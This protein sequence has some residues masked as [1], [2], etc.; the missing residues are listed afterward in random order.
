MSGSLRDAALIVLWLL[1]GIAILVRSLW[2]AAPEKLVGSV[3]VGLGWLAGCS[4]PAVWVHSGTDPA[5]L[6]VA[7]GVLYTMGALGYHR[8]LPDPRPS[9]FGYHEVFHTWV[10]LAAACQYVS[11]ACVL[12]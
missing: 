12:L 8:R 9:G 4:V 3:Y 1:A 11:I 10:M 2:M 6:L 5:S 7:G